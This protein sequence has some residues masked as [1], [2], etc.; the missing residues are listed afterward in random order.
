MKKD[1]HGVIL[2]D[3]L[4]HYASLWQ[5]GLS[6]VVLSKYSQIPKFHKFNFDDIITLGLYVR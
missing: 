4:P 5:V 1:L 2:R 6:D 3:N